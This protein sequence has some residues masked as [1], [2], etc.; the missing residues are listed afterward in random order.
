MSL[1]A[2]DDTK[3]TSCGAC[4][5]ECPVKIIAMSGKIPAPV[6][7]ANELCIDCG[8]CVTVC[9]Y[10]ALSHRAMSPSQCASVP[11]RGG[12][13][14]AKAETFLRSRR[15]I[16]AFKKTALA[17]EDIARLL[18]TARYAPSGHNSQPLSWTVVTGRDVVHRFA[19]LTAEWLESVIQ[20]NPEIARTLNFERIVAAWKAGVDVLTRDA[21]HLVICH[22]DQANLMAPSAATIALAYLEL[23]AHASGIGACWSG[24]THRAAASYPPFME[25]LALPA[26]HLTLGVMLLGRPKF[27]Y[28][29]IPVRKDPGADWRTS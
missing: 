4:V 2:V 17:K 16:R 13:D 28:H 12:I 6:P 23:A 7:E 8:H 24:Y 18:D 1:F 11:V 26:G 25:Q 3:C 29:R 19:G 10:A 22:A 20:S 5:E 9:P 15:S 21:P 27:R 14:T